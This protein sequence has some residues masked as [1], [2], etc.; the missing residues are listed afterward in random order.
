LY[1]VQLPKVNLVTGTQR[2]STSAR[3]PLLESRAATWPL[4]PNVSDAPPVLSS[5][6]SAMALKNA[7]ASGA[8]ATFTVFNSQLQEGEEIL[9]LFMGK[10]HQVDVW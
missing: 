2:L 5:S 1:F 6:A 4:L 10:R 7:F 3:T 9:P 8:P